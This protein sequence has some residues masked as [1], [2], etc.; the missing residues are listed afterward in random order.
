M[1]SGEPAIPRTTKLVLAVHQQADPVAGRDAS[2]GREAFA[3]QHAALV[4]GLEQ[5]S[6]TQHDPIHA[7][8]APLRQGQHAAG[9]AVRRVGKRYDHVARH[10]RL[11]VHDARDGSQRRLRR[12][13]SAP[14][15]RR[16]DER[17]GRC[18]STGRATP[19]GTRAR[20][21]IRRIRPPH[22]RP[23]GPSSAPGCAVARRRAAAFA[24]ERSPSQLR[25]TQ[26]PVIRSRWP[27]CGR[28]PS[29]AP[30]RPCARWRRCA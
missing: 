16:T 29:A 6:A 26:P 7:Q 22:P 21:A 3:H 20:T 14:E 2:R 1:N 9:D 11:H 25:R 5:P 30:G 10:A 8:F 27:R 18:R 28:R 15:G 24:R 17:S 12:P 4:A 23:R 19:A 13:G